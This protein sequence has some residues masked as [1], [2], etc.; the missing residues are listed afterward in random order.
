MK[1]SKGSCIGFAL[2]G[3]CVAAL[4]VLNAYVLDYTQGCYNIIEIMLIGG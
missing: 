3:L 4:L 1:L 2:V